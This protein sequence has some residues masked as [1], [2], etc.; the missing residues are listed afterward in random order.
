MTFPPSNYLLLGSGDLFLMLQTTPPEL[1]TVL[2]EQVR[3]ADDALDRLIQLCSAPQLEPEDQSVTRR[4]EDLLVSMRSHLRALLT[5]YVNYR[6]Q[7]LA[8]PRYGADLVRGADDFF[9]VRRGA[10]FPEDADAGGGEA[11]VEDSS[12]LASRHGPHVLIARDQVVSLVYDLISELS[13]SR[14]ETPD[15]KKKQ[16]KKKKKDDLEKDIRRRRNKEEKEEEMLTAA[17]DY[18]ATLQEMSI[19]VH[20]S[21]EEHRAAFNR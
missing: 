1:Q 5:D 20:Q 10:V 21:I 14:P 3:A 17:S 13:E 4:K 6:I 12:A 19:A 16:K 15:K 11:V 8:P 7:A 18:M 2:L 9:V